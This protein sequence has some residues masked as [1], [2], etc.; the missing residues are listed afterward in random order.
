[1]SQIDK[2]IAR[3]KSKPKD[4]T[5]DEAK[6]LLESFGYV[7]SVS[8]KTSGSRVCLVRNKKV[9]RM[10][11]PHPRKELL[12]YQIRELIDELKQEGLL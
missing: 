8:G 11:K 3:L 7:M 6:A 5:F 1:M 9:F 4:F 12:A 10:H 2:L